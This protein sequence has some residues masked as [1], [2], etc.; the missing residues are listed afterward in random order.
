MPRER[1]LPELQ[2]LVTITIA[3]IETVTMT[4]TNLT[5]AYSTCLVCHDGNDKV[6]ALEPSK[7]QVYLKLVFEQGPSLHPPRCRWA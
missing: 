4:T 3:T 7:P 5:T 1:A 2:P 6:R